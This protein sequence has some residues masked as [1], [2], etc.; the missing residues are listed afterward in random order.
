MSLGSEWGLGTTGSVWQGYGGEHVMLLTHYLTKV[1]HVLY[2]YYV[3]KR[4]WKL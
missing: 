3:V 2:G 4:A 1:S